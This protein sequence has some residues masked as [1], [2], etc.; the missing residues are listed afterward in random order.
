[1]VTHLNGIGHAREVF[2]VDTT[3]DF[4]GADSRAPVITAVPVGVKVGV[5]GWV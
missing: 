3:D 1:M 4:A 2:I 5:T